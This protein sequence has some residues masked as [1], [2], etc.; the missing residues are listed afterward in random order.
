MKRIVGLL[1]LVLVLSASWEAMAL[2][3]PS[4]EGKWPA[5]WPKELESLRKKSK[6][7]DVAT[8][9][10]EHIYT[11]PFENRDEFEKLWPVLVKLRTPGSP[12]T[13]TR[14]STVDAGWGKF[15]PNDKPCVRIKGPTGG[16]LGGSA[17]VGG[18]IDLKEL[19]AG[20]MLFVGVPWPQEIIGAKGELPEYVSEIKTEN[21]K[22]TWKPLSQTPDADRGFHFR[23]RIDIELVL[24]G[25][26]IDLNRIAIPND[27]HIVDRRFA[28]STGQ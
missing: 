21:G 19:E 22:R 17:Q 24:D 8:G 27:A 6:T 10:Q 3:I 1:A 9:T 23:A 14:T 15:L 4:D 26:V 12:I 16:Y 2:I 20:T 28:D 11:I 5:S 25:T 7:L 13:L 18:Q